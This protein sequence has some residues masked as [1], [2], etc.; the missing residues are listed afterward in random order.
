MSNISIVSQSK[1]TE[2]YAYGD[3]FGTI[4]RMIIDGKAIAYSIKD[5]IKK[6]TA[7]LEKRLALG[8]IVVHETPAIRQFVRLK[9][10]FGAS[11]KIGVEVIRVQA[12]DER[13]DKVLE[14]L[15]HATRKYDGVILQLPLPPTVSLEN[16]LRIYPL[17]HDVDVIGHT[18]YQQYKEGNL[19][20]LP[21]VVGAFDEILKRNGVRLLGKNVVIV[22]EGRLVGGPAV[23]WVNKQGGEV[24]VV[25][26]ETVNPREILQSAD[27]VILGA[28]KP[29]LLQPDMVK[30][31]VIILDAGTGEEAGVVKGDADPLCADK[32][33][34]FTPTPGGIGPITVAKVFE[35]LVILHDLKRGKGR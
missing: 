13:S 16:I 5:Q 23:Y 4:G 25:N 7:E 10:E 24:T 11:V 17:T 1:V 2:R 27:V 8:I 20:L 34:L 6:K 9:E 21:P 18:A 29:G 33:S 3:S 30:D 28:G 19:P 22:G 14:I 32:A 15:L 31:G 35:N 26:E 12:L